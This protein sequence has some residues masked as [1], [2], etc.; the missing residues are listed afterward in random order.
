MPGQAKISPQLQPA[1]TDLIVHTTSLVGMRSFLPGVSAA[2]FAILVFGLL[3]ELILIQDLKVLVGSRAAELASALL[4][5]ILQ[6]RVSSTACTGTRRLVGTPSLKNT[7][8]TA[9]NGN[10]LCKLHL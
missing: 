1:D 8:I 10:L 6:G 4:A 2:T 7:F 3:S 5:Y 9:F